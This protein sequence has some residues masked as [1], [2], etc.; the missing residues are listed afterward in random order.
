VLAGLIVAVTLGDR[1]ALAE[2]P[3]F[4][5]PK[6]H[7]RVERPASLDDST[8][9]VV[10]AEILDDMV[11]GY[12]LSR[13]ATARDYRK[14]RR[15][16]WAPYRSATHG[17]RFVNNYGNAIGK[18]YG[19]F[20]QAGEMPVGTVLAKD[21]VAVT[22]LGDVYPGPLFIMEKMPAGFD[23]GGGDWRY[24]MILPDGS[25]FGVTNG[26]QAERVEFCRSCHQAAGKERDFLFFVPEDNRFR[27]YRLEQLTD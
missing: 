19:R 23:P 22:A 1:S 10:Y 26:Q 16:N 6:R 25:Y 9:L 13:N 7:F 14:W 21:S 2:A 20:E 15:Y 24:S 3:D 8:A 18:D 4:A 11:R 17:E 5:R 12:A 27:A